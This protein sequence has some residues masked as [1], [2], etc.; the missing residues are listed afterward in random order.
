[1]GLIQRNKIIPNEL[2]DQ[3]NQSYPTG[4]AIDL[5][6]PPGCAGAHKSHGPN[7]AGPGTDCVDGVPHPLTTP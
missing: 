5:G 4:G 2:S 6:L 1:M 7:R 3:T